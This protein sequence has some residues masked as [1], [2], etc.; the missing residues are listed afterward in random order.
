MFA[1][2]AASYRAPAASPTHDVPAQCVPSEAPQVAE[3]HSCA[4]ATRPGYHW[5]ILQEDRR[6]HEDERKQGF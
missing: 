1:A 4:A 2:A 3:S 6:R 5:D